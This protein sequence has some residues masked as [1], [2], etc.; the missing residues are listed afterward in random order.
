MTGRQGA[1]AG[2]ESRSSPGLL[3]PFATISPLKVPELVC[4][5]LKRSLFS[6]DLFQ[7]PFLVY[8]C[9]NMGWK[10]PKNHIKF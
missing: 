1:G 6:P 7:D 3:S 10:D 4:F 8:L 5:Y 2:E 9:F